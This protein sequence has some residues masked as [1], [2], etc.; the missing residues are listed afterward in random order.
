MAGRVGFV[1][2]LACHVDDYLRLRRALGFKLEWPGHLL[3]QLLAFHDAAGASTLTADLIIAWAQLPQGVQPL[4]WAHRLGAARGFAMYLKTID[5]ATEVPPPPR[6]VF[7]A[8]QRR[9]PPY[10]WSHTDVCRLLEAYRRLQPA[11]RAAEPAGAVDT[12]RK[13][14][15][16]N[17]S[18]QIISYA[19]FFLKK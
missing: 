14:T 10:L 12:D 1:S 15:R 16:L 4:H 11:L 13:S 6:D 5:P 7:G 19:L 17:S 18:H 3:P 9:P 2:N 8:H